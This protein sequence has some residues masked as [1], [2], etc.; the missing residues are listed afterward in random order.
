MRERTYKL[1][2]DWAMAL[3]PLGTKIKFSTLNELLSDNGE[4]PYGNGKAVA[5]AISAAFQ[6]WKERQRDDICAAIAQTYVDR[7]GN[8][9]Y[10]NK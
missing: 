5:S 6:Y 4:V 7:N 2:G 3:S 10:T 9:A 8:Y 1:I